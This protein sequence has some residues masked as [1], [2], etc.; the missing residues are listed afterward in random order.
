MGQGDIVNLLIRDSL[1]IFLRKYPK[2]G[3][4]VHPVVDKFEGGEA[5]RQLFFCPFL[6]DQKPTGGQEI[7]IVPVL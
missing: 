5:K 7:V 6:G 3:F 2:G 1:S 4:A